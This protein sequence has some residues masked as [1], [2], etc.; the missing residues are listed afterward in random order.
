MTSS[1]GPEVALFTGFPGFIGARLVPRLLELRPRLTLRCLV[2]EKFLGKAREDVAAIEESFPHAKKRIGL[3]VGDITARGLGLPAAEAAE[4]HST[5]NAA[6]HL[7]AV[8]DLAVSREVGH[9]VNVTG[10]ANVVQFLGDCRHFHRL[11]YVST[12]YVSGTAR[13]VFRET[14]LDVGQSFKNHYEETKFQAE[15]EVAASGL[16]KTIYRPGIVVGDSRTGETAK[17]DGPYFAVKAMTRVPSPGAFLRIGSGRNYGNL[18]PV[19]FIVEA[20]AQLAVWEGSRDKTY[21]LTDPHPLTIREITA[22]F[23]KALGKSF[24]YV[25]IPTAVAKLMFSPGAV[26]SL[27]G[28]PVETID[29]FDHP[30]RYDATHATHDLKARGVRCPPFRDYVRNLIDYYRACGGRSRGAMV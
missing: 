8:Y 11:H 29:Y 7:A 23:A 14:D 19:D 13:G 22:L 28:M 16:P 6:F 21:H 18:V 12:A 30:C 2:Q 24:V 26:Q 17:F 15:M 10:T 1:E 20:L 5:V 3:V 25:P 27:F 4:L 9:L